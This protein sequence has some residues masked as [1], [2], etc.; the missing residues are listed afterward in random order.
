MTGKFEK[1]KFKSDDLKLC[2]LQYEVVHKSTNC[3]KIGEKV[4]LKSNPEIPMKV[5]SIDYK[6][7]ICKYNDNLIDFPP[8][9]ILQYEYSMFLV[10]KRKFVLCLN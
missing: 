5:D 3:F 7:V 2:D 9:C 1:G 8:E 6:K 10:W 4:F